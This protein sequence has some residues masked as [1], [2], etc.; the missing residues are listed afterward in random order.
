MSHLGI[1][2]FLLSVPIF[3]TRNPVFLFL[4]LFSNFCIPD[5]VLD[6]LQR[7]GVCYF[8]LKIMYLQSTM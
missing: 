6:L 7:L 3:L 1:D 2:L 8:L 5:I 4:C